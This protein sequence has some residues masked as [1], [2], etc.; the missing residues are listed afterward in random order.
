MSEIDRPTNYSEVAIL[1]NETGWDRLSAMFDVSS[2]LGP[3][4]S[5][6]QTGMVIGGVSGGIAGGW[7]YAKIAKMN[8]IR[9]N[10]SN[11]YTHT[12]EAA[13]DLH[14]KVTM[15]FFRG[16]AKLGW[17]MAIFSGLFVLGAVS[18]FTYRNKF[19]IAEHVASGALCGLLFK[20]N[21]GLRGSIVGLALGSSL[22]LLSGTTM[23]ITTKAMGITVPEY[24]YWQHNY[25]LK[26]YK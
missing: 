14:D 21:M 3:E 26:E 10:E 1:K 2:G 8:F 16:A 13:R 7:N 25:W 9:Q 23:C 11:Y 18:G 15:Q 6:V 19:G 17:R 12:K 5:L 22:G 20:I 4:L 24:R